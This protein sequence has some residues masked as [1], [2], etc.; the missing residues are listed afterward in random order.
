MT[1]NPE[2]FVLLQ[3][4]N[5][6]PRPISKTSDLHFPGLDMIDA[7]TEIIGLVFIED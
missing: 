5:D 3:A 6:L 1:R 4:L 7:M 2:T